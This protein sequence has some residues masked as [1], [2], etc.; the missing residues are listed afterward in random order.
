M[1]RK[2]GGIGREQHRRELTFDASTSS[3]SL[4]S[5]QANYRLKTLLAKY[6]KQDS[7][8]SFPA[9]MQVWVS[10]LPRSPSSPSSTKLTFSSLSFSS[11]RPS[12]SI[13]TTTYTPKPTLTIIVTLPPPPGAV[14]TFH[15]DAYLPAYIQKLAG[16][17]SRPSS[18]ETNETL[19]VNINNPTTYAPPTGPPPPPATSGL[20]KE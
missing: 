7:N 1:V 16:T 12:Q 5:P 4:P 6:K 14:S 20:R 15:P 19:N 3:S 13:Q 2:V 17:N 9:S 10:F 8:R 11:P 18:P